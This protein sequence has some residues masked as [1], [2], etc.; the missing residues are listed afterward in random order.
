MRIKLE[1]LKLIELIASGG[2][3]FTT[4]LLTTPKGGWMVKGGVAFGLATISIITGGENSLLNS[5]YSF[6]PDKTLNGRYHNII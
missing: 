1:K 2:L 6:P 3:G 4:R 5:L